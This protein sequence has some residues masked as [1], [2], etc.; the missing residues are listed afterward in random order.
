MFWFS[1]INWGLCSWEKRAKGGKVPGFLG[2]LWPGAMPLG[3][4]CA[5]IG[6][7]EGRGSQGRP[8]PL[9]W[10][11]GTAVPLGPTTWTSISPKF[12]TRTF[13]IKSYT[14]LPIRRNIYN[15]ENGLAFHLNEFALKLV[16]EIKTRSA[17]PDKSPSSSLSKVMT[18]L[19][20]TILKDGIEKN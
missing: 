6:L 16:C 9:A 15:C 1:F 8:C 7:P 2:T 12:L 3:I 13:V 20:A 5:C 19:M 11:M 17:P 18:S 10:L 14:V 4:P